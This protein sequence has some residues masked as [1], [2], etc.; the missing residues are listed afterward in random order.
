M[1]G[2]DFSWT[3][4]NHTWQVGGTFK[5]IL[6]HDD[7]R[8]R[9]QHDRG[10]SRR[11]H[12]RPLR[13]DRRWLRRATPACAP[14]I[15]IR[16]TRSSGMK[17]LRSCWA[18][19]AKVQS[20]YNYNAQGKVLKQLSGD[21]RFYRYYQTQIYRRIPGRSLPS[22]TITYG[23]TYQLFTVPY[24]DH[25]LESVEPYHLRSVLS[26]PRAAERL[27]ARRAPALFR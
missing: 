17:R 22:L 24:E 1:I 25:G 7:N 21:Q 2:D 10:R 8:R 15:S 18:A 6:A 11:L 9:L 23:V 3:K 20:D 13:T 14:P 16:T 5:D 4:G 12:P 27:W 19:S 26:G